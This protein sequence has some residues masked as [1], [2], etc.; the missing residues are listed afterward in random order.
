MNDQATEDSVEQDAGDQLEHK[1]S[2]VLPLRIWPA[3]LLLVGMAALIG[4]R[5]VPSMTE[6]GS[7]LALLAV[8]LGPALM[9]VGVLLWW[10]FASRA[11]LNE[12]IVGSI[13]LIVVAI[14]CIMLSDKTMLG[15]GIMLITVPMGM[16]AFAIST[17]VFKNHLDISRTWIALIFAVFGFAFTPMLRSDGMYADGTLEWNWRWSDSDEQKLVAKQASFAK[18]TLARIP[19]PQI[20]SWLA[21]PEWP[22][23]RGP[24]MNGVQRGTTFP[25]RWP[26]ELEQVWKIPIGPG[27]S[28]FVVAGDL[29]FTQEQL[30]EEEAITCY[31]ADSGKEV[32][33][34]KVQTRFFD[35][36][37]GAGPRATPTLA[38][39]SLF[40]LGANGH[41]IKLDAKT[42]DA[43]WTV[44]IRE[45]SDREPPAWGFSS[46]PLVTGN[47]VIVHAGGEGELG[48][49]AYDISSGDLKWSVPAGDHSYSS[50][51]LWN[52]GGKTWVLMLTNSGL[53]VIDPAEGKIAWTYEWKSSGYRAL[54]PTVVNNDIIMLPT[55][56]E[57]V[58]CI[59]VSYENGQFTAEELWTSKRLRPDFNDFV[60]YDGHIYGFDD[61][62]FTSIDLETGERNWKKGRYGKGQVLLLGDSGQLLVTS[63]KGDLVFLDATPDEF[64][65]IAKLPLLDGKTWNHPVVVGNRL[66]VRNAREAACFELPTTE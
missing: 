15:P 52:F 59:Q 13:G 6:S 27:W 17:V 50:P 46:S 47:V 65:E 25:N 7:I 2:K 39:N 41:L 33:R 31:K 45:T 24:D 62:V 57:G 36:I 9:G 66:Y 54:Q 48:T 4:G 34:H 64:S 28:S 23:F 16:A 5:F 14:A 18:D 20:D 58:R 63:E 55:Q 53:D 38:G 43:A 21:K 49:L 56:L 61:S 37:G 35:P 44:D 10:A 30:G 32:W 40:S 51:Q 12:K 1:V 60:V 42:G 11:T 26:A 3:I 8:M 22:R 19:A 29:L